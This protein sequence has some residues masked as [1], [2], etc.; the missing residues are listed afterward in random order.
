MRGDGV[1]VVVVGGGGS[2]SGGGQRVCPEI[3]EHEEAWVCPFVGAGQLRRC[4]L[5]WWRGCGLLVM[6]VMLV[7]MA[8]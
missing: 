7:A 6:V 8:A 5:L 2:R 1:M 3:K 4:G